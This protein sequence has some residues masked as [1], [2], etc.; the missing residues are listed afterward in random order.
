MERGKQRREVVRQVVSGSMKPWGLL[1][2][3]ESV[4]FLAL[5]HGCTSHVGTVA[6]LAKD[7]GNVQLRLVRKGTGHAMLDG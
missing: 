2:R 7:E 3:E 6:P 5:G 1:P 4:Y